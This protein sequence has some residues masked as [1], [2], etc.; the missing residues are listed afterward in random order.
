LSDIWIGG[1][2]GGKANNIIIL[3]HHLKF[4]NI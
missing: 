1:Y 4:L 3:N 2:H